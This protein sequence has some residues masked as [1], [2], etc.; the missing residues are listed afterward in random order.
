MIQYTS[1]LRRDM[2]VSKPSLSE[3][4]SCVVCNPFIKIEAL[5]LLV[6]LDSSNLNRGMFRRSIVK[7]TRIG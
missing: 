1:S 5:L 6:T 7:K 2:L 4:S 3:A